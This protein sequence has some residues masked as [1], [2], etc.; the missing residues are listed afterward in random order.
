MKQL[1]ED[2]LYA[3]EYASDMSKPA[4]MQGCTCPICVTIPKLRAQLAKIASLEPLLVSPQS[5]PI[6]RMTFDCSEPVV[7]DYQAS[8]TLACT[9]HLSNFRGSETGRVSGQTLNESN[10]PR[11]TFYKNFDGVIAQAYTADDMKRYGAERFKQGMDSLDPMTEVADR[12]AHRLAMY[13]EL[14]LFDY[15]GSYYDTAMDVLAQYRQ[16]MDKI[17][18]E[19]CP[20]FMGEPVVKEKTE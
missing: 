5:E 2:A 7:F 17:T 10:V 16:D 4:D 20:T 6:G 1:L 13:L 19:H 3:L 14:V 15:N 9:P 8:R 12:F 18:N 11:S